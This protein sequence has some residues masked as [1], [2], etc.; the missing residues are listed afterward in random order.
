VFGVTSIYR[1]SFP[2]V[3][4]SAILIVGL[5]LGLAACGSDT[6]AET[7]RE[8]ARGPLT[9]CMPP[10]VNSPPQAYMAK[11]VIEEKLGRTVT[12]QKADAGVCYASLAEGRTDILADTWMPDTHRQYLEQYQ[13]DIVVLDRVTNFVPSGLYVPTYVTIDSITE[14]NQYRD[15]FDGEI[16]GIEPGAGIMI[17]TEDAIEEYGLDYRLIESSDYAMTADFRSAI[18]KKEW[19]VGTLWVPHWAHETMDLK[20]LDDPQHVYGTERWLS[21]SVAKDLDERAPRVVEFLGN[22]KVDSS[23]WNQLIEVTAV[24]EKDP[25]QAV[26]QWAEE[27]PAEISSWLK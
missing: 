24:K 11:Y 20:L 17:Q 10:W 4:G 13:N 14:L 26:R 19:M 18:A 3:N 15:R 23:V 9:I 2:R 12:I 16:I 1:R 6:G 5:A 8:Q 21:V 7:S 27:N 22:W 25:E